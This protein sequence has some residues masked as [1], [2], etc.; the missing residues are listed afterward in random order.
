[1]LAS[2]RLHMWHQVL[3]D[4]GGKGKEKAFN[5][6]WQQVGSAC[7]SGVAFEKQKLPLNGKHCLQAPS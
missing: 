4:L 3:H 7:H 2:G 6:T 1:M 5:K